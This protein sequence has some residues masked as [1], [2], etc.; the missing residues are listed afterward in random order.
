ML[1]MSFNA[2]PGLRRHSGMPSGLRIYDTLRGGIEPFKSLSRRKVKMLVCGPTVQNTMHVGHA[3]TEV[4]FDTV[5]RHLSHQGYE[6]TFLMNMTD[7]DES[8]V[9]GA[10]REKVSPREY[11][12]K[13]ANAFIQDSAR[14]GVTTITK[15]PKVSDYIQEMIKET[16][17]LVE[18]GRAYVTDGE[19]YL[20]TSTVPEFG[21]L[22]HLTAEEL[23]LRPVEISPKKRHLTDFALWRSSPSSV[24]RWESPWGAGSP[25]WHIQ[26][27]GVSLT[28][29]GPQYDIHGGARELIYPHHESLIAEA[30]SLT[31]LKPYVRFWMHTGLLTIA[32]KKMSKSEGNM[33]TVREALSRFGPSQ[34]RMYFLLSHYREDMEYEESKLA[35]VDE[36]FWRLKAKAKK[37]KERSSREPILGGPNLALRPFVEAM[38]DDFNTPQA[39][40]RFSRLVDDGADEVNLRRLD[41]YHD[42]VAKASA[43]LGV[44][45]FD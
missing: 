43:I 18:S 44:N 23:T 7:I 11:A 6:V 5:A 2:H 27:T 39:I 28:E 1:L 29:L 25:G 40:A 41:A 21:Q 32:K 36:E 13:Y 16:E 26:D 14:L 12:Q 34:L 17:G 37:I 15:Y 20:D 33:V 19:V 4:F 10:E 30:E 9:K 35:H 42:S 45:I 8:I 38:N 24:Q 3:R 31:G 22:S